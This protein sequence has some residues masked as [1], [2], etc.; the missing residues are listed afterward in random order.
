MSAAPTNTPLVTVEHLWKRYDGSV[1]LRDLTFE[2]FAGDVVGLVGPNGSGKS[3]LVDCV[4]GVLTVDSGQLRLM[5]EDITSLP[6]HTRVQKGLSRTFQEPRYFRNLSLLQHFQLANQARDGHGLMSSYLR[7]A[8]VNES[9]ERAV[10]HA[11]EALAEVG[12]APFADDS[13]AA[14]SYGQAK[15]FNLALALAERPL[16]LFLD[17]PLAGV[18][19]AMVDKL[20][21]RLLDLRDAGQTIVLIEHDLDFVAQICDR[22]VVLSAGEK[23]A[24]GPPSVLRED[25]NVFEVLIGGTAGG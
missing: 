23:I 1:A 8:K 18:S 7:L 5:D 17:E 19:P 14:L 24:E 10:R 6:T 12:L 4:C 11:R 3:T 13:P 20:E 21:R 25:P 16:V 2:V 9:D 15:L 22:V